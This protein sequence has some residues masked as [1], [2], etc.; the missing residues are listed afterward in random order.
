MLEAKIERKRGISRQ[1][2]CGRMAYKKQMEEGERQY[3]KLG[4]WQ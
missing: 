2:K 4:P 3:R 1:E